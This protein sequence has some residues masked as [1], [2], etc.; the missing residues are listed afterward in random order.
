M[1]L[2]S[3]TLNETSAKIQT[4]HDSPDKSL[5]NIQ[6][7]NSSYSSYNP[8]L[9]HLKSIQDMYETQDKSGLVQD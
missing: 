5:S 8:K 1:D 6:K 2:V 3:K 7:S 4:L 9:P